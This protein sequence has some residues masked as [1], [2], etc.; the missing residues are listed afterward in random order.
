[1]LRLPSNCSLRFYL[2]SSDAWVYETDARS[3]DFSVDALFLGDAEMM[4]RTHRDRLRLLVGVD[5][6]QLPDTLTWPWICVLDERV[7]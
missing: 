4:E 6:T 2:N 7:F 5:A 1:M 3:V